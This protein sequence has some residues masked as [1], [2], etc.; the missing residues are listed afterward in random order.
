MTSRDIFFSDKW[1]RC[2]S[3]PVRCESFVQLFATFWPVLTDGQGNRK[4]AFQQ[5]DHLKGTTWPS[6]D[7]P[8]QLHLDLTVPDRSTLE[9]HH[10]RA[11]ASGAELRFDRMDDPDEPFYIYA[12][13]TGHPFCILVA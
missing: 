12:D 1:D 3:S 6:P 10:S 4:L 7:V 13:P 5:V 2:G 8:M 9:H 11:L